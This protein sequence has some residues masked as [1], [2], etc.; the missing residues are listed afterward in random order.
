MGPRV[1]GVRSGRSLPV[2]SVTLSVEVCER[3]FPNADR[4]VTQGLCRE[5][6][7]LGGDTVSS[8]GFTRSGAE[9]Y[10][11]AP[12]F[13][14]SHATT[15][16]PTTSPRSAE[17]RGLLLSFCASSPASGRSVPDL[18]LVLT[19]AHQIAGPTSF[20]VTLQGEE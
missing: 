11:N 12:S 14:S 13:S 10:G 7:N 4:G 1:R 8:N 18:Y 20:L 9:S 17:A 3:G 5:C 15:S 6:Q 16:C 19:T 2:C